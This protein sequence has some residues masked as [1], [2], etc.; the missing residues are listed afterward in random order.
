MKWLVSTEK[1]IKIINFCF[2]FAVDFAKTKRKLNPLKQ[3]HK[4]GSL[5]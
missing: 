5:V 1:V 2:V 4:E 3:V